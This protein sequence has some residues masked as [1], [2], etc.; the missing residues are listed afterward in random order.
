MDFSIKKIILG[1]IYGLIFGFASPIPGVSAGTMAI[2]LN[3]YDKFFSSFNRAFLKR[4]VPSVILFLLG[5]AIGLFGIS[6]IVIFLFDNHGQIIS[7]AF[8]GLII[9]CLPLIYKKATDGKQELKNFFVFLVAFGCMAFLAFFGGD[10]ATN[11]TIYQLGINPLTLTWLFIASFV[12]S[13]AMLIPG[14]GGSLMMIAFGIYTIYLESV[15]T[16]NI[17]V[18][19]I[20]AVSMVLGVLAGIVITRKLLK[21]F[22]KLLYSAICGFIVGSLLIIFPGISVDFE[23]LLSIVVG[24][25]CFGFAYWLSKKG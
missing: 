15:S 3:V 11:T 10:L 23:S 17:P 9:G 20:F 22:S 4:N 5:W 19:I 21:T 1:F 13:M 12:S 25:V 2:L 8:I 6:R 16:F 7:F 24:F 18:L 14:V